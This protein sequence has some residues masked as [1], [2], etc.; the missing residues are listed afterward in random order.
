MKK[1]SELSYQGKWLRRHKGYRMAQ[2]SAWRNANPEKVAEYTLKHRCKRYGI[3]VAEFVL[4]R[5]KQQDRCA[6]CK[7]R[8]LHDCDFHID[9]DHKTNKVRGLLCNN[10]NLGIG[11]LE[12]SQERL[13]AA[14]QYLQA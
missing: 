3:T 10:C 1:W 6:I 13:Q 4:L 7:Q 14:I 5:E 8:N 2:I 9:H 11:Y 12:E